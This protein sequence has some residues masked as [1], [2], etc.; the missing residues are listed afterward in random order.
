MPVGILDIDIF[1]QVFGNLFSVV[2]IFAKLLAVCEVFHG[3]WVGHI[4]T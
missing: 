3:D 1:N 2:Y 4:V